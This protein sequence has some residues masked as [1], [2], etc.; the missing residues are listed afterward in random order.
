MVNESIWDNLPVKTQ[1]MSLKE[2][3]ELG[4]EALFNEKYGDL[5]R[6]VMM[7]DYSKELCGGIHVEQ[8][9]RIGLFKIISESS[10]GSG[11][12]RIEAVTGSYAL[13]YFNRL[14]KELLSASGILKVNPEG[15]T[16]KIQQLNSSL[17]EKDKE[18]EKLKAH[19][20]QD[21]QEN[22]SDLAD[23]IE[24]TAVLVA[25]V[26]SGS[27]NELR[28]N[29]ERLKDQLGSAVVLLAALV[30][31]KISIVCFVSKD[32]LDKGIHA[33]QLVETIAKITGG[34]GGGRPD[35]AQAGGKNI[36][37]LPEALNEA[38]QI[39]INLLK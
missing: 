14:E 37:K 39:I 34:G 27:V 16:K 13:D 19:L 17:K 24:G 29:A 22:L 25:Q 7:G 38:R 30:N 1:I 15:L 21:E 31:D 8:T 18:I 4:A 26:N 11:L 5:V 12:R 32:L 10:V 35:M 20:T 23:N 36:D 33:G 2:A 6:V 28:Q 3:K 9:G